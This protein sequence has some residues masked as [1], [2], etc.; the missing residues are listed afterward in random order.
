MSPDVRLDVRTRE[1]RRAG[2]GTA[3]LAALLSEWTKLRTVRSTVWS[4][5]VMVLVIPAMAVVTTATRSYMPGDTIV[6]TSLM[7]TAVAQ[8]LAVSVGVLVMASEY[9]TG[10]IRATLA[11]FPQRGTLLAAKA[12]VVAGPLFVLCLGASLL[13]YQV[14]GTLMDG[15]PPSGDLVAGLLGTSV[16]FAAVGLL[17]LALAAVLRQAVG[18]VTATFA[19][20]LLPYI[21]GGMLPEPLARWVVAACPTTALLKLQGSDMTSAAGSLG[22]WPSLGVVAA[23]TAVALGLGAWLLKRRD[24]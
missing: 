2:F 12:V 16:Y 6:A 7:G 1:Q 18:A 17:G 11:A 13:A 15:S 4:L 20:V 5:V 21:F 22:A 23:Y 19:G 24:A 8:L 10:M 9:T 3:L 14:G